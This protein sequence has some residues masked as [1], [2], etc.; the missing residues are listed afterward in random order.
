MRTLSE[1]IE[2]TKT[3]GKPD[4]EEL[5]YS[6]LVLTA[7]LNMDHRKLRETL[8]AEK[9]RQEFIRKLEAENSFNM[10]KTALNKSPKDYLGWNNDPENPEYQ[11]FHAIGSKLVDKALKGELPNQ[12]RQD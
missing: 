10:Y 5:R 2:I 9:P 12:K 8:L 11:R 6:V 7:L 3:N 1:I 4:Y